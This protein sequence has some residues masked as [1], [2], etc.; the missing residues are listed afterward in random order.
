MT[1]KDWMKWQGKTLREV[2][3]GCASSPSM[4]HCIREGKREPGPQLAKRIVRFTQRQVTL[5]DL[6]GTAA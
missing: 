3:A 1:L 5:E 4:I 6:Y 2:A